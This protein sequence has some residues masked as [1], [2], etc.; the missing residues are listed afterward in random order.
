[1]QTKQTRRWLPNKLAISIA[2]GLGLS[3]LTQA[4]PLSNDSALFE[5]NANKVVGTYF[6][7]WGVYGRNFH[8]NDIPAKNLTHVLYGFIAVC[9]PNESLQKENPQGYSAL[10]REC[11]DQAD[12]TVTIHDRFAALEKSYPGDK[13]D[14]P[15][16]GNFGQL[17][18]LKKAN[19]HLTVL[20]SIGGWTLSD[21]FYYLA[22]DTQKRATFVKSAIEFLKQ[23][24]F[25]D[26]LD[27]DWEFPGVPGANPKLGSPE[28][29]AAF[30]ALMRDLRQALDALSQETGKKYQLTAAT[31][32][33]PKKI[34]NI[35]YAEVSGYVDYIFAMTYDFYGAWDSTLGHHSGLYAAPHE[36]VPEFNA[37]DAVQNLTQ[38]GLPGN[39]LVLGAAMYGRGWTGIKGGQDNNPWEG[40]N[41][42]PIKGSWQPGVIDY[43]HI[44]SKYLGGTNGQGTSGFKYFYDD[45]AQAPYLWNASKGE[46]ITYDNPRSVKAKA[47]YV[48]ANSLAGVFS[49]EI[50]ADNGDIL[51]AIH[52]G[53]GNKPGDNPKP[54]EPPTPPDDG[55]KPKPPTP[56]G[57]GDDD[58]PPPPP[59]PG[60]PG[61]GDIP[62]PPPPGDDTPGDDGDKPVPPANS[63]QADQV[64]TKG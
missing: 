1:M 8:V 53:L 59:P 62:P 37:H 6:V 39:K 36:K 3:N 11:A 22:K 19:P 33:G 9:G 32:A 51:K 15:I 52:E 13:W 20:P 55:D 34:D 17:I 63:W 57:D 45:T 54:P 47:Q 56:P 23:Y 42:K 28:D 48:T 58:I 12:Y 4:T 16:R 10:K 61:D 40:T 14:D 5:N 31:S 7:E 21:P 2:V 60:D 44:V 50:D 30:T 25:F 46:L 35:N 64:Y 49:W 43:K 29:K 27:I 41:G 18:K 26:G 38:A 24:P